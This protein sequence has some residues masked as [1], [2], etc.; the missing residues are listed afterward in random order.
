MD[1]QDT[2]M[3]WGEPVGVPLPKSHPKP[4]LLLTLESTGVEQVMDD[5]RK[6]LASYVSKT[7]KDETD[8]TELPFPVELVKD[9]KQIDVNRMGRIFKDTKP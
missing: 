1:T 5:L 6:T 7:V 8:V 9:I 3:R 4:E 2:T